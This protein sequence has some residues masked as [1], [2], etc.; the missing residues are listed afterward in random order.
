LILSI[1]YKGCVIVAARNKESVAPGVNNASVYNRRISFSEFTQLSL[2]SHKCQERD[3][4]SIRVH[5]ML[6]QCGWDALSKFMMNTRLSHKYYEAI[7]NHEEKDW[8]PWVVVAIVAAFKLNEE[9]ADEL[10]KI[11]RHNYRDSTGYVEYKYWLLITFKHGRPLKE[12]DEAIKEVGLP[13]IYSG[14]G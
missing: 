11:S 6:V 1:I 5:Q 4:F 7:K 12:W 14:D 10:I 2:I 13:V 9:E 3:A 8:Q